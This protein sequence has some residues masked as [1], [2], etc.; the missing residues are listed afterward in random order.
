MTRLL[1]PL[2]AAG[3]LLVVHEATRTGGFGGEIVSTVTEALFGSLDAPPQ[4]VASADMPVPFSAALER[5]VFSA[6][7]T[8][9]SALDEL[10][11]Y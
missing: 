11:A 10:L 5:D 8:L 6:R 1:H 2:V 4:R 9:D 3:R 7:S